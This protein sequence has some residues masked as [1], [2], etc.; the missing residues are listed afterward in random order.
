MKKFKIA[1]ALACTIFFL[2]NETNAEGTLTYEQ[3]MKISDSDVASLSEVQKS[4]L[5]KLYEELVATDMTCMLQYASNAMPFGGKVKN[6]IPDNI[7]DVIAGQESDF[8]RKFGRDA[9]MKQEL[10]KHQDAAQ[11]RISKA[12]EN[13]Q[14]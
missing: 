10:K 8:M 5:Y 4:Q 9:A 14:L 2:G 12:F 13:H 7:C 6:K 11:T 1:T 3:A